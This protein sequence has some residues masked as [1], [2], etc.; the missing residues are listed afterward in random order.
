MTDILELP[1]PGMASYA[2]LEALPERYTG[3]LIDGTLY[4]QAQ[5]ASPHQRAA[6][7]IGIQVGSAFDAAT[8]GPQRPGGWWILHEPELHF[9]ADVLVP[10]VVGW[11]RERMPVMPKVPWFDLVPDWLCEVASPSSYRYDRSIKLERYRQSGVGHVWLVDPEA[12]GIEVLRL[13]A[14]GWAL[15]GHY[16]GEAAASLEPFAVVPIELADLWL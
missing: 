6:S 8:G 7:Q 2:D 3:E 16:F 13:S 15:V 5:P 9:G 4:A 11:R 14:E 12:R 10:D 1:P